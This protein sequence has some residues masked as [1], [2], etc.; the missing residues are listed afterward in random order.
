[1]ERK[2]GWLLVGMGVILG[3]LVSDLIE[4]WSDLVW[5]SAQREMELALLRPKP[6]SRGDQI[7]A[8]TKSE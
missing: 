2:T 6:E 7:A 8:E 4:L 1:M 3:F 5:K